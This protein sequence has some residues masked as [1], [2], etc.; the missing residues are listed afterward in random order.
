MMNVVEVI[1][2]FR[3]V[4]TVP[5]DIVSYTMLFVIVFQNQRAFA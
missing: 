3:I 5:T 4:P 1:F 2:V